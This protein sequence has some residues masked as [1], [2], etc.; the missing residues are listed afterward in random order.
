MLISSIL[1]AKSA[2]GSYFDVYLIDF[3]SFSNPAVLVVC[4]MYGGLLRMF[5]PEPSRPSAAMS[6]L[7]I[8]QHLELSKRTHGSTLQNC[9]DSSTDLEMRLVPVLRDCI[10]VDVGLEDDKI[11]GRGIRSISLLSQHKAETAVFV[12]MYRSRLWLEK[13]ANLHDDLLVWQRSDDRG[14]VRM[15]ACLSIMRNIGLLTVCGNNTFVL[16]T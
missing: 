15:A 4:A 8:C 1:N 5:S 12:L 7:W 10:F 9:L 2:H 11:W 13:R 3:L 16:I 6:F 14:L